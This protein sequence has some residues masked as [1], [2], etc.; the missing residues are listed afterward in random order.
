MALVQL[1]FM[2]NAVHHQLRLDVALAQL[3]HDYSRGQ[4]QQ[5]IKQGCVSVDGTVVTVPRTRVREQQAVVIDAQLQV[6]SQ[7]QPEV[8]PY[9]LIDQDEHLLIINKAANCVVHPGAGNWQ[10][11]LINALLHDYPE[12]KLLPRCGVVHRL[13]K[14]TTGLLVVARTL[15]AM[16]ALVQQLQT[17][18]VQRCYQALVYGCVVSG[19]NIDAPIG[20]DPRM[21]TR[22]AIVP[23]GKAA[24]TEVRIAQRLPHFTLLKVHLKTGRTHQIRVHCMAHGMPLVGDPVYKRGAHLPQG[25]TVVQR[26]AVQAFKRQALH[27][28]SL[29]LRHPANG[30]MRHWQVPMPADMVDL[31]TQLGPEAGAHC[32]D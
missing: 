6:Q 31:C 32:V 16:H 4:L 10:G 2:T 18:R 25:L 22:M 20:R 8:L 17:H 26:Q 3:A 1:N 7:W 19:T 23:T 30:D 14:D 24:Q 27:A 5:W 12:L 13:D 11:T 15:L 28:W 29:K 21:R 9:V